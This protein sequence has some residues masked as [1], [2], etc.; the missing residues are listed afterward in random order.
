MPRNV[1]QVRRNL[2]SVVA[3]TVLLTVKRP[4]VG[5]ILFIQFTFW[6]ALTAGILSW[7]GIGAVIVFSL[8]ISFA[9]CSLFGVRWVILQVL[10]HN[11]ATLEARSDGL[12]YFWK[13]YVWLF[14]WPSVLSVRQSR[15]ALEITTRGTTCPM[16]VAPTREFGRDFLREFSA[17]CNRNMLEKGLGVRS[18]IELRPELVAGSLP[19]DTGPLAAKILA[20]AARRPSVGA[21][22]GRL[23]ASRILLLALFFGSVLLILSASYVAGLASGKS[24]VPGGILGRVVD[25]A[26]RLV[27][28]A[29]MHRGVS[30]GDRPRA[31]RRI[32][33]PGDQKG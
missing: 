13:N 16:L 3:L 5:A 9:V 8:P 2:A 19:G 6:L 28:G 26:G 12:W 1:I 11:G 30:P 14:P 31:S 25:L 33:P 18:S 27:N 32:N 7:F 20:E 24:T 29:V 23:P 10:V 17:E 4:I 21:R 15:L 22:S